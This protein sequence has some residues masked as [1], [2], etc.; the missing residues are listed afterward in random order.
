MAGEIVQSL[1][2]GNRLSVME[3][4][5]IRSFLHHG[6]QFHLYTYGELENIPNGTIVHSGTEI[7]PAEDIF[8]YRKG[9]GKG[10]PAVFSDYFRYKLLLERGGWWSDLDAVCM[11]P[12]DFPE[13][14]VSCY[15]REKD[16]SLHVAVGLMKLP[17]GS[18]IIQYCWNACQKIDKSN[19]GWG[20]IGPSLFARA[21]RE[22]KVPIRLLS[23]EAFY[24]IDHW[25]FKKL[26]RET[27]MPKDCY[28]IHLWSSKWRRKGLD[29]NAIYDPQC[30][31]EQLKQKY[32]VDSIKRILIIQLRELGDSLLATPVARQLK[33]L[34]PAALI[35]V[36]CERRSEPI[37]RQNPNI[38]ECFHLQ[39]QAGASAFLSLAFRLRKRKY[40]LVIDTQ[41]LPKTALLAR[42]TGARRR[43]GFRKRWLRNRLC[44]TRPYGNGKT[45]AEYSAVTNLKLLQD[46]R[47]DL[48]DI[49]LECH[50]SER[51]RE[52]AEHFRRK[53]FRQPVAA[54]FATGRSTRTLWPSG[55]FVEIGERIA[56]RGFQ[57][58]LV[59]GPGEEEY[60]L[61]IAS[62]MKCDVVAGYPMVSFSVL[63]GIMEGCA[64]FVGNDGGPKHVAR[65][66]GIP[67]VTIFH[68]NPPIVWTDPTERDQR[69]F[70]ASVADKYRL[71]LMHGGRDRVYFEKLQDISVDMVWDEIQLLIQPNS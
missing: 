15:E 10:S 16:G 34:Y 57:P 59:Y 39:R 33:R 5:C 18:P 43:M 51:D 32:G 11:K 62:R 29:I 41:S 69:F 6:Y 12:L 9:C 7:L 19:I 20:Q 28:S 40:D 47:V 23:P 55:N 17:A 42:L 14:H 31:Y 61:K 25:Q 4:L 8:V 22:V 3:Q 70:A 13:D 27:E 58:F 2:I 54:M 49:S 21:I 36:V 66:C 52:E 56:K 45:P 38:A 37:F 67:T 46:D 50:I 24:P 63:K 1:W 35:D 68:G 26:V 53:W 30:I 60:N 64:I 44:Y 65:A 71:P 48:S